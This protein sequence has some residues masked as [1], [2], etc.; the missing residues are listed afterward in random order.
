MQQYLIIF[1]CIDEILHT[2]K[3]NIG[4]KFETIKA[5]TPTKVRRTSRKHKK[6]TK[7]KCEVINN[8]MQIPRT[9][10]TMS[11]EAEKTQIQPRIRD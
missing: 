9:R 3:E 1:C 7:I 10:K 11:N 4:N 5:K 6:I 2:T 8:S